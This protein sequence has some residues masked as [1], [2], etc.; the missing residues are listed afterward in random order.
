VNSIPTF[1]FLT[2]VCNVRQEVRARYEALTLKVS[3]DQLYAHVASKYS[4]YEVALAKHFLLQ[5]SFFDAYVRPGVLSNTKNE[6]ALANR[7]LTLVDTL[8]QAT[9]LCFLAM[10]PYPKPLN[11][12]LEEAAFYYRRFDM[13]KCKHAQM[14]DKMQ[15]DRKRGGYNRHKSNRTLKRIAIFLLRSMAPEGMWKSKA[16]AARTISPYLCEFA[17]KH[18]LSVSKSEETWR[19]NLLNLMRENTRANQA[20]QRHC[21][22]RGASSAG[23]QHH[24]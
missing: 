19:D 5:P 10:L 15:S 1:D 2:P 16:H 24:G 8:E 14:D 6:K 3:Y 7:L 18:R 12:F 13:L 23:H 4:S 21:R 9:A 17:K 11:N 20:F 22:P